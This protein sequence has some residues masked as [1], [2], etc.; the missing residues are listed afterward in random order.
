[1][2]VAEQE[3]T[4]EE[5]EKIEA[6]AK[7]KAKPKKKE[8]DIVEEK[9]YT[10]PLS[11]ALIMP[12]RKRSPRAMRIVRAFIIKHMKIP[13][14]AEEEDEQPPTLTITKEVNERIWSRGIEKPPRKI[15]VRATKDSDGNVTVHL[16]EGD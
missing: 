3:V 5:A 8:E 11:K 16:A 13:S 10:I 2:E 9:T 14:R 7:E 4:A 12:P 15:R 6:Q 1:M